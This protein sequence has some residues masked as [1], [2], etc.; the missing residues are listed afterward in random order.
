M[1]LLCLLCYCLL[2]TLSTV[3]GPSRSLA[4][5]LHS[6][7]SIPWGNFYLALIPGQGYHGTLSCSAFQVL[8]ET[9]VYCI[10]CI[11]ST[12]YYNC[13][14]CLLQLSINQDVARYPGFCQ[15]SAIYCVYC[16]LCI[17]STVYYN[18]LLCLL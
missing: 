17:L 1:C 14:L 15:L 12:V 9:A 18:C 11:L 6:P 2:S 10:L 8:E 5:D 16:I 13:L 4:G 7:L 3:S